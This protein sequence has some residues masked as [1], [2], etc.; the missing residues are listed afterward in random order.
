[1]RR[2][3][4]ASSRLSSG[5]SLQLVLLS[6]AAGC[7]D[8]LSYLQLGQVFTSAMTGNSVLLGLG[9]GQGNM[10]ATSRNATALLAFLIGLA[11]GA[12]ALRW[13]RGKSGRSRAITRAFAF[14]ALLLLGFVVLWQFGGGPSSSEWMLYSLIA[15]SALAMGLQSSVAHHIGVPGMATTY[16]TGTLTNIVTGATTLIGRRSRATVARHPRLRTGWQMIAFLTYIVAAAVTG[17]LASRP[18]WA[19]LWGIP[20]IVVPALP[21]VALVLVL[22]VGRASR[23][24]ARRLSRAT[25]SI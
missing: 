18:S 6:F 4:R 10:A 13:H 14:E 2:I 17:L 7:M 11:V 19:P 23:D 1:M 16:F 12:A 20:A 9:I 8:I 22:L 24:E 15:L 21:A 5:V 3:R 25:P